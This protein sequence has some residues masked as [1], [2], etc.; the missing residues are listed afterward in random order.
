M[1]LNWRFELLQLLLIGA[2]FAA[3][4]WAWPQ[5]PDRL[6]IHWNIHGEVDG[7]GNKFMGLL[8]VPLIVLG[9]YL[10]MVIVPRFD[11][12]KANY[13]SFQKVYDIIRI[14][15]VAYM[16]AV[17]AAMLYAAFGHAVNMT[18]VIL[19][20]VGVLFIVLGNF[21]SKIRPNWFVGVRTPWTLSSQLSWDKTHRLAGWL[22][23]LMGFLFVPVA[24]LQT[25]WSLVAMLICD[26]LCLIW[27]VIYSYL[28]FRNDPHR[29]P[30]AGISPSND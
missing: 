19:P 25:T 27:I 20:L 15:I 22:F 2:M 12:G 1:K 3:A 23:V 9:I 16:S 4:A 11:P 6:P 30:P 29:M 24:L 14:A 21:L 7:W 17:Y 10:L 28:V 26:G 5:L 18:S 8:F 13:Q